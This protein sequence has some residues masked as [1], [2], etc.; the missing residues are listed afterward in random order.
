MNGSG[1]YPI[2]LMLGIAQ[3][4]PA[5]ITIAAPM[6]TKHTLTPMASANKVDAIRPTGMAQ[7]QTAP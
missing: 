4:M 7:L 3:V 6:S 5:R 2:F 1:R